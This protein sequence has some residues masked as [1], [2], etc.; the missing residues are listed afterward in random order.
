M[1]LSQIPKVTAKFDEANLIGH[2]GLLPVMRLA[3]RAGLGAR[4]ASTLTVPG[5]A[6]HNAAAKVSSIVAGMV[7]G[8][9]S[10]DDLDVLREGA[11]GKVLPGVLAPSTLG[12]F[13]RAF[14]FGHVRQLAAV[15]AGLLT[16]LAG[17]VPLLSGAT[18]H[19][20]AV[21]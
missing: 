17:L 4:V 7:A 14:T 13:L 20:D 1:Q 21:T 16:A 18:G 11:T 12:T 9:D 3:R 5:P 15:A 2:A 6:G 10:I 19:R 8:A